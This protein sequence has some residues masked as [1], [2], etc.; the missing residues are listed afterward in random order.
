[1][2]QVVRAIPRG[3]VLAY[4][5]VAVFAGI[6]GR[7]RLVGKFMGRVG[8]GVPWWRVVH[9]DRTL[10]GPVAARQGQQLRRE[11]VLV[12]GGRVSPAAVLK[13]GDPRLLAALRRAQ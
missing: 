11:G 9:S 10:A 13:V 2:A 7:A 8:P 1:V 6:P 3:K 12:R 5:R 4:G